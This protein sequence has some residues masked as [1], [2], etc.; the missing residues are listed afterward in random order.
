[1][2]VPLTGYGGYFVREGL[3]IGE[4]NRVSALYGSAL[5]NAFQGIWIQYASSDQAAV[6][7]YPAAVTAFQSSPNSYQASLANGA[8]LS[9]QIQVN[10]AT[11][12]TPF[13]LP[14]S[15]ALLANQMRAT[16]DSINRPTLT[17]G[18]VA[19]PGNDGDA[20]FFFS[21]TNPY[22]DQL[23]T[24][25]AEDIAIVCTSASSA[26]AESFSVVGTP[27]VAETA[28][29]WPQGSGCSTSITLTNPV[30]TSLITDG[31]FENWT[32]TGN[33]TPVNWTI[34]HGAAGTDVTRG[35]GGVRSVD[36]SNQY[37]AVITSDGAS[38]TQ[39]TQAVSLTPNTVYA[40]SVQAK[41]SASD[42]S[43]IFRIALTDGN[44]NILTDDAGG[45]LSYTRNMSAQVT[46][47]FQCFTAFFS[48]PRLL[49]ASTVIQYGYSVAP[50][51]AKTLTLDLAGGTAATQLYA[52]G[53]YAIG[54]SAALPSGTNDR[55]TATL[56]NNLGSRSFVRGF[57]RVLKFPS[58]GPRVYFP[59]SN[60]PTVADSLIS[61]I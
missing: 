4:F 18:V 32:G 5:T 29:N 59:S 40:F 3:W 16:G 53:P 42:G 36:S 60:S 27:A 49:P 48:T 45:S 6:T 19:A 15:V 51:A 12:L 38:A 9:S 26:F 41:V 24:I 22:G 56:T 39:L 57:Q 43:G 2:S 13:S 34:I 21:F 28:S 14:Q 35:S 20:K 23:D 1:M 54:F 30:G 52:Q 11:A 25:Y 37:T 33:N 61:S 58:L 50:T 10:D 47:N 31:G 8:S 55:Y 46:T 7:A 44:G 17:S